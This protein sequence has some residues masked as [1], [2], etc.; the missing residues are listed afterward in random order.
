[1]RVAIIDIIF[2]GLC[3]ELCCNYGTV[4]YL[5]TIR[6]SSGLNYEREMRCRAKLRDEYRAKYPF[7]SYVPPWARDKT[8]EEWLDGCRR[9]C[10]S[11]IFFPSDAPMLLDEKADAFLANIEAKYG[12]D[13][14]GVQP[15]FRIRKRS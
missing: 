8:Y 12:V 5:E 10:I 4:E 6:I 11:E 2:D 7:I 3:S 14:Y 9:D 13:V 1:L 15:T